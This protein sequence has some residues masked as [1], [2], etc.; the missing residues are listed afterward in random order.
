VFQ[1]EHLFSSFVYPLH[2]YSD[3]SFATALIRFVLYILRWNIHVSGIA[4]CLLCYL[5]YDI[6]L[7]TVKNIQSYLTGSDEHPVCPYYEIIFVNLISSFV[8]LYSHGNSP[9]KS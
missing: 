8:Y 5:L 7:Q 4:T 1:S 2:L 3:F 6:H 9:E